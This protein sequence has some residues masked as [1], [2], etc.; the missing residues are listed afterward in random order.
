M[1]TLEAII[2]DDANIEDTARDIKARLRER[3]GVEHATVEV[4][5]ERGKAV[6]D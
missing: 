2:N 5:R 6:G 4:K 3:F 1:V